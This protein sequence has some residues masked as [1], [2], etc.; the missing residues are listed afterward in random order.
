[1]RITTYT[2]TRGENL[3]RYCSGCDTDLGEV[4]MPV[5][6]AHYPE[7]CIRTLKSMIDDIKSDVRTL[8]DRQ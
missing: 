2:K 6:G 7:D 3:R 5:D 4:P 8:F 1:M